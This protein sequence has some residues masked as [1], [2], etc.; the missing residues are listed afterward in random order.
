MQTQTGDAPTPAASRLVSG[1]YH[2]STF[3]FSYKPPFGWV[4]RTNEMQESD[5]SSQPKDPKAQVL[6]AVFERPP[7]ATGDAINSAVV[8]ATESEKS[9]PGLKSAADYFGPLEEVTKSKGFQVTNEPYEFLVGAKRIAREDFS[10]NLGKLTM[11]Q[12]TLVML[13]KGYVL[14]FTF[15]GGSEDEIEGL[16]GSLNFTPTASS[17]GSSSSRR[18]K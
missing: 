16:I 6:L 1:V 8:I 11:D 4:E 10:K 7:E 5:S 18:K 15:I 13:Q 2:N 9:Y 17:A 3:G 14:S 12:S